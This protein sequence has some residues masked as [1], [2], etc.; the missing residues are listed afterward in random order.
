MTCVNARMKS[1]TT[2]QP[3]LA[4]KSRAGFLKGVFGVAAALT[5][6]GAAP[7][8]APAIDLGR[9]LFTSAVV[10]HSEYYF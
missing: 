1:E 5:T 8:E 4:G 3:D 10:E 6:A 7:K 2:P 9:E